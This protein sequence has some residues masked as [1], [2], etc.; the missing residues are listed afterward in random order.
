MARTA[1]GIETQLLRRLVTPAESKAWRNERVDLAALAGETVQFS[2]ESVARPPPGARPLQTFTMGLWGAPRVLET[3][4]LDGRFD[5]VLVSLDTLRADVVGS[6]VD[7]RP[8]TPELDALAADGSSFT[9]VMTTFPST[10]AAHMSLFTSTYPTVH[11]VTFPTFVLP[12]TI[13]TLPELLADHGYTTAAVTEGGMLAAMSGFR[14]GF[15]FYREFSGAE[16]WHSPRQ[17]ERTFRAGLEWIE[18]HPGERFFLFLHTYQVH[19][20]YEPPPEYSP[21]PK[22]ESPDRRP[23]GLALYQGEVRYTDATVGELIRGLERL[24]V[25]DHA[26]VAITSDHGEEFGEHGGIAHA[27]TLYD[28]VMRVP[29]ILWGPGVIAAGQVVAA[30][31]SLMDVAPTL[32]ELLRLP[33]AAGAQGQSLVAALRGD[34]AP[35]ERVRFA[36]GPGQKLAAGALRAARAG[37]HKWI[38]HKNT[39]DEQEIFDLRSDPKEQRGLDD[40]AL[41]VRGKQLLSEFDELIEESAEHAR[42]AERELDEETTGKLRAL[43]YVE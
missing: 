5:V 28:E 7:G 38:A 13:R 39:L 18:R 10:S 21:K 42:P 31:A 19:N 35:T 29:L 11:G 20:P 6:E 33:P 1:S 43:G 9:D 8:L 12:P 30:P 17:V 40:A 22:R 24:G 27:R 26:I 34:A 4:T 37:E 32:L 25:L 3:R 16:V 15:D 2:F 23:P 36:E 14:R 41:R